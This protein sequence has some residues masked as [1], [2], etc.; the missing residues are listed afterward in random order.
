M[1]DRLEPMSKAH[2][3]GTD[4]YGRDVFSRVVYGTGLA[5]KTAL[6]GAAI[7]MVLGVG[8]GLISGYFGKWID[9]VIT[10]IGDMIWSLPTVI[11]AM[12]IVMFLGKSLD[13][14]I[15]A[16]ALAGWPR[17]QRIV[18]AKTLSLKDMPYTETGIAFGESKFALITQYIFPNIL[19]S[20]LV[21]ASI[22]SG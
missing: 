3:F 11:I 19:P 9:R 15:I 5:L 4:E 8:L 12:A 18:R 21:M 22:S 10:F 1:V 6:M 16:L 14:V 17:Y 20:M 13:N 2:W 7:E